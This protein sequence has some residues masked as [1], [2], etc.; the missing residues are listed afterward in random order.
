MGSTDELVNPY[1][2]TWIGVGLTVALISSLFYPWVLVVRARRLFGRIMSV[3][4][5]TVTHEQSRSSIPSQT[6]R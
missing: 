4:I 1:G 3:G 5:R 2:V 6:R